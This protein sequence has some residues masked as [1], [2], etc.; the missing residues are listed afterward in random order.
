VGDD[1]SVVRATALIESCGAR[2]VAEEEAA[3]QLGEALRCLERL[4]VPDPA[5]DRLVELA[6]FVAEREV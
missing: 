4:A 6:R 2:E 5:R 3:R 1:E